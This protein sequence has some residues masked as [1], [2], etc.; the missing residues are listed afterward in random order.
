MSVFYNH[1]MFRWI[2]KQPGTQST[3]FYAVTIKMSMNM[4]I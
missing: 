3:E 2:N 4:N 1:M